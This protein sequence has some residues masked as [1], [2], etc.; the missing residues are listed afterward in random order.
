LVGWVVAA[1]VLLLAF[2]SLVAATLPI[3]TSIIGLGIGSALVLVA[4]AV[5]IPSAAPIVAVMLGLGAGIDYALFLVT[6]MRHHLAEGDGVPDAIAKASGGAGEA[7]VFA[8]G[9]VVVA[10][11]GLDVAGIPFVGAIGL[12]AALIAAV[13]VLAALPCCPIL[14]VLGHRVNAGRLVRPGS[15]RKAV[16]PRANRWPRTWPSRCSRRRNA[17]RMAPS[18]CS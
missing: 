11:L 5:N 7:I 13:M 17:A 12:A 16:L 10:I 3:V 2:D 4:A 8:G 15:R 1:L 18:G 9:T 14:G 6:R